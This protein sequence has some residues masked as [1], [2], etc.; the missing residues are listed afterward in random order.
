MDI[1]HDKATASL[2]EPDGLI[3]KISVNQRSILSKMRASKQFAGETTHISLSALYKH[4]FTII[5]K[6]DVINVESALFVINLIPATI[7]MSR[8]LL[9]TPQAIQQTLQ[10]VNLLLMQLRIIYHAWSIYIFHTSKPMISS[11]KRLQAIARKAL[12]EIP[13]EESIFVL[14]H[15]LE[16]RIHILIKYISERHPAAS[17]GYI[18]ENACRRHFIEY[19]QAI[20]DLYIHI[21]CLSKY[22]RTLF[23]RRYAGSLWESRMTRE[24]AQ[25]TDIIAHYKTL[26]IYWKLSYEDKRTNKTTH[27]TALHRKLGEQTRLLQQRLADLNERTK[28]GAEPTQAMLFENA[29]ESVTAESIE[30]NSCPTD[31]DNLIID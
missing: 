25:A 12:F 9:Y 15:S 19:L 6:Q 27:M 26:R 23:Y 1:L 31:L 18:Y 14:I 2:S 20:V 16:A 30:Y 17:D 11:P 7:S 8:G 4:I 3:K 21:D 10:V 29:E 5:H 13:L 24:I 28:S 22:H